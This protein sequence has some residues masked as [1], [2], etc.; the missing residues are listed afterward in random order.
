MYGYNYATS[1]KKGL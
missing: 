1:V